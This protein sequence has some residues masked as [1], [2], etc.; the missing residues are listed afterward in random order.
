MEYTKKMQLFLQESYALIEMEYY[1]FAD[2]VTLTVNELD[3]DEENS[4]SDNEVLKTIRSSEI[5]IS[6]DETKELINS[7]KNLLPLK[8]EL[9]D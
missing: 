4:T 6:V 2:S 9:N 8:E 3:R 7:L 5:Y 1:A